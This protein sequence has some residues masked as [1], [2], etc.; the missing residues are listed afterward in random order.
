MWSTASRARHVVTQ[1]G[2][3]DLRRADAEQRALFGPPWPTVAE[4]L[5]D[6][7]EHQ[8]AG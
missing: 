5:R 8:L 6:Y 7:R 4:G 2:H 3:D 1:R